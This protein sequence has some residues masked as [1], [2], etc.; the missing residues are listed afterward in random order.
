[1]PP[2]PTL[3]KELNYNGKTIVIREPY[4]TRDYRELMD[5]QLR[6][7]GMPD[8][9][10]AVTYHMII[11]AHRNGGVV[12][13]A[14]EKDTGKAVGVIYGVPAY[15]DGMIYVYSHLAGVVPE[16]RFKGLGYEMKL[17]QRKIALEKGYRLIKWTYDPMQ[18]ANA[19]FNICKFG[20]VVR[21]FYE[22]YYGELQDEINRGMPSDRFE[23]EWWI[24]SRR[25]EKVLAG[26]VKHPSLNDLLEHGAYLVNNVVFEDNIPRIE[27]YSL[28]SSSDL[29]LVEIPGSLDEIR[30]KSRELVLDWRMKLRR[31]FNYYLNEMGYIVTWFISFVENNVR[32]SYYVLWRRSLE[33]ILE[34]ELP[35][36]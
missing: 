8:Y 18:S 5:V 10:E 12:L 32:R 34:G 7:W 26:E 22:D 30:K 27:E 20:V 36:S 16:Y 6:I 4:S 29:V 35:W 28:S 2:R 21:K 9:S 19:Y 3:Y 31:I 25:V 23:A 11:A 13:G 17:I 24:S 33:K 14:F 1:M 15:K